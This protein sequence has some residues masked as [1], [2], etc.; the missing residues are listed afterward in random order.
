NDNFYPA[1]ETISM[2]F[3]QPTTAVIVKATFPME[4]CPFMEKGICSLQPIGRSVLLVKIHMD[5]YWCV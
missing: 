1:R 2:L 4:V 3:S 5:V